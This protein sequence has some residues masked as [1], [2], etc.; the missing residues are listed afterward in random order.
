MGFVKRFNEF[1][2]G[3]YET[4]DLIFFNVVLVVVVV[5]VVVVVL[6]TVQFILFLHFASIISE[7]P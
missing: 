3:I 2:K 6:S 1:V 5:V 4:C 7:E